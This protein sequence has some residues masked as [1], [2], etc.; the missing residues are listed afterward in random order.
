MVGG[1]GLV[2]GAEVEDAPCA[3]L[4]GQAGAEDLAALEPGDQHR[5]HRLGHQERLA[6]HLLARQLDAGRR[7]RCRIGCERL[8]A[9][10]RS[11]SPASR[12]RREQG[13]PIR[14]M[15]DLGE[16]A[17]VQ[18]D[19]PHALVHPLR[20]PADDRV[21]DL[22]RAPCGPTRAARRWRRAAPAGRPCS[23]SSR[24]AVAGAISG[25]RGQR[26]GDGGVDAVGVDVPDHRVLPLVHE[27][28]P[29]DGSDHGSLH[30]ADFPPA[31]RHPAPRGGGRKGVAGRGCTQCADGSSA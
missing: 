19:Q 25:V 12:Q 11:R 21:G 30:A 15:K 4:P 26:G 27:L 2:A 29:D 8:I 5:L 14:R 17:G 6:V 24:V 9:Q 28:V 13:V 10:S 22:R 20:H 3:A 16:V 18:H 1:V 31:C 7:G 23:G